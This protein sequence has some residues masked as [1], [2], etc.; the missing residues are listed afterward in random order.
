MLWNDLSGRVAD[1]LL[2]PAEIATGANRSC[3]IDEGCQ[4]R[5]LCE[6]DNDFS[7]R[8]LLWPQFE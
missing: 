4:S 5:R 3:T 7:A 2:M 6:P 1:G 8:F